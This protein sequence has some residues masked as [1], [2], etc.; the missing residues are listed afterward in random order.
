M[1]SYIHTHLQRYLLIERAAL[2]AGAGHTCRSLTSRASAPE[3]GVGNQVQGRLLPLFSMSQQ[4]RS[5]ALLV[6]SACEGEKGERERE[7][8]QNGLDVFPRPS[9]AC[10]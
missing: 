1:C 10:F 3:S 9:S 7:R 8:D 4:S 6:N 2:L 5:T